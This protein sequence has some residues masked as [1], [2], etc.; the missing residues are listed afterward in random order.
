MTVSKLKSLSFGGSYWAAIGLVVCFGMMT[1]IGTPFHDHDFDPSHSDS[2]CVSC[3]LANANIG[4]DE[5]A[6]GP[7][8]YLQEIQSVS[9]ETTSLSITDTPAGT[10]RA[11]PIIC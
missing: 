2:D 9:I 3:Y 4:L 6:P 8:S 5:V 7:D 11:P 10:S 1:L